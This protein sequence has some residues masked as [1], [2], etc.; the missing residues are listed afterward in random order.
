ME[1]SAIPAPCRGECQLHGL[2]RRQSERDSFFCG[3]ATLRALFDWASPVGGPVD[4]HPDYNQDPFHM[5]LVRGI[6]LPVS[7]GG[8]SG[9]LKPV[10]PPQPLPVSQPPLG[11][12]SQALPPI[13]KA[14]PYQAAAQMAV[15]A[16]NNQKSRFPGLVNPG[17][18]FSGQST[19]PSV[20]GVKLAPSSQPSLSTVTTVSTPMLPQQQAPPLKPYHTTMGSKPTHCNQHTVR[21]WSVTTKSPNTST[22]DIVLPQVTKVHLNSRINRWSIQ[23]RF[24]CLVMFRSGYCWIHIL[25]S[26]NS[27]ESSQIMYSTHI[28]N[29]YIWSLIP[30]QC[31]SNCQQGLQ[32]S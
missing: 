7:S 31:S 32:Q 4:P 13:S 23:V 2:H 30:T 21:Q 16:A 29:L 18:P 26:P 22:I 14:H 17:P 8:G 20:A 6:S 3:V 10:L 24:V 19:L 9:P 5:I 12:A 11:P 25:V 28:K 27:Q 1:L 15:E